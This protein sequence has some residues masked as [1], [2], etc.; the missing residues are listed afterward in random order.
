MNTKAP[1]LLLLSLV[2]G[3]VTGCRPQTRTAERPNILF[4]MADDQSYPHAGAYGCDWVRTPSFDRI[5]QQGILFNRAFT[6]NAK[7]APSRS[8]VVTG[9]TSWQLEAAAN[10]WCY[11][12]PKFKTYAECLME[13]GYFVGHTR[14]GWAPGV[15]RTAEGDRRELLGPAFN[16]H[17]T[18][19][20]TDFIS[21]NDYAA[22]FAAFLDAKPAGQ[23]FCFWYGS[24][25]PHRAYE[26]RSGVTKAGKSLSD[27]DEV[28]PFWPDRDTVRNDMLDYALEVEYF[29]SHIGKMLSMLEERDMLENT[30]VI[31]T[32]DHGMPFPRIKGM[33]NLLANRVPLA[34]MWP[35]GIKKPGRVFDGFVSFTDFAPTFL[36]LAGI[37]PGES[38]MQPMEGHSLVALLRGESSFAGRDF[39]VFGKERTDVGRP[40]DVGY[41]A[42]GIADRDHVYIMNIHPER[43]P[44]GNPETGYL[45]TDGSP[46]KSCILNDRRMHGESWFWQ[47][48]FG[49]K[50]AE[51]LYDLKQ[52]PWLLD[53]LAGIPEYRDV[54]EALKQQLIEELKAE[55]DPRMFGEGDEFDQYP[56]ADEAHR[57][58]YN[59]MMRGETLRAGWV[60]PTDFEKGKIE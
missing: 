35:D 15:A 45:D 1:F 44:A 60:S 13:N 9:R 25:E 40:D 50:P 19:P 4:C 10:H 53:N 47:L 37:S 23:P 38:G 54:K 56:Y 55:G 18:V 48:N 27:L 36:E 57:D 41:P 29:D 34:I 21:D 39:M 24:T 49:M 33:A 12:P 16:E 6:P 30:L 20:P 59:R 51:E 58:F 28:P 8:C 11:F 7:C 14:K 2:L 26:Y 46:T 22:N 52:D 17:K 31:V 5:A 32:S 43:W 42:R 3:L